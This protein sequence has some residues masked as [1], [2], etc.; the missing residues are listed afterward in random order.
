MIQKP[1]DPPE[2]K[3]KETV[4]LLPHTPETNEQSNYIPPKQSANVLFKFMQEL[5]YLKAIIKDKA[6]M[7]RYY[8]EKIDYLGIEGLDKVAFPMSCFCDIHLNKLVPHMKNYGR[9][10]IGLSKEWGIRKGIQPIHYINKNSTLRRD[11]GR[12]FNNSMKTE[13]A[14]EREKYKEYNNYLLSDLLFMKPIEGKMMINNK[15]EYAHRNFHDEKEWRFVPEFENVDTE[16]PLVIPQ[17]QMN[18]HSYMLHSNGIYQQPQLWL[19][20]ELD[21]IKYIIVASNNDRREL[22]EFIIKNRIVEDE[23]E[24]YGLFSKI[25]VFNELREDW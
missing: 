2:S 22:L 10:G 18:H 1:M 15:G 6:I 12:V 7:P 5:D 19:K 21:V 25:L 8:E 13:Q 14:N 11:F 20:F 4:V 24:R 3:A 9:Y 17:N 16:L 23:Y